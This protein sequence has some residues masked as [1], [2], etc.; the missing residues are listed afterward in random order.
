MAAAVRDVEQEIVR[1][2]RA[3]GEQTEMV[4]RW[5]NRSLRQSKR[6]NSLERKLTAKNELVSA[7]LAYPQHHPETALA[8][9]KA[10]REVWDT[11]GDLW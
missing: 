3:L 5:K 2:H 6:A 10:G 7:T 9:Y 1:L 8:N 4:E 11:N